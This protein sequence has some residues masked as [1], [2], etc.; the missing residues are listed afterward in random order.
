[1]PLKRRMGRAAGRGRGL[2]PAR[3]GNRQERRAET[4]YNNGQGGVAMKKREKVI[5]GI[6]FA[7]TA[8]LLAGC[9][10]AS[11]GYSEAVTEAAAMDT[12]AQN[13][14]YDA[15]GST[16]YLSDGVSYEME[17][18]AAAAEEGYDQ[19]E[20]AS[21]GGAPQV[22]DSSRKLI[23]NVNLD[24]ET[25]TFD[26]LLVSLRTRI[27]E[28]G[29]YIEESTT[30]NGSRYNSGRRRNASLTIRVPSE[31]LD[32]FLM[33]V[34]EVS[35]VISRNESVTDVT[36]QYVD[37]ESHKKALLA[38]QETLLNLL[39]KAETI[40]D[41]I[42]L[43]SRLSEVR[44][45]IESMES[46]LRT[47]DNQVSYSTVYLYI[48]EV[49]KLTPV[50]EQSVWEKISTGFMNSLYDVGSGLE[51]LGIGLV[52]NLPYI[53][54]WAAVIL[55]IFLIIRL[56]IRRG[57]QKRVGKE[58]EKSKPAGRFSGAF[59]PA[60]KKDGKTDPVPAQEEEAAKDE[61]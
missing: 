56:M 48:D 34:A 41:I 31:K 16:G 26:D 27:E 21:D 11:K 50:K 46:Q 8:L 33:N 55:I 52:I 12:A 7:V 10:S 6:A 57:R 35:N 43:E 20:G 14:S 15:G 13:S 45:Q 47:M 42:S 17:E 51:N 23:R 38:E 19:G 25:E 58:V 36:L 18:E 29:G 39:K 9:G 28:L 40:E 22:K 24:V 53:L 1:M 59:L 4:F 30:Y 61:T 3:F 5:K 44:Y 49:A 32:E 37:M 54:V 60:K 2:F